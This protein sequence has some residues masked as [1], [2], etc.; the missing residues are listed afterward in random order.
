[1]ISYVYHYILKNR[2]TFIDKELTN[3]RSKKKEEILIPWYHF[4]FSWF[5]I[6]LLEI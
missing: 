5:T 4:L 2:Y 3:D 1:V 6:V